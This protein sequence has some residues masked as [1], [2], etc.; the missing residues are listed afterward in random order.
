MAT[1]KGG[2][3]SKAEGKGGGLEIPNLPFQFSPPHTY[4]TSHQSNHVFKQSNWAAK[5]CRL[6]LNCR[7]CVHNRQRL[8]SSF[9][10]CQRSH[11]QMYPNVV[12]TIPAPFPLPSPTTN[13]HSTNSTYFAMYL[14]HCGSQVLR[15]FILKTEP[16]RKGNVSLTKNEGTLVVHSIELMFNAWKILNDGNG[17]DNH[18]HGHAFTWV[19]V[20]SVP[21]RVGA[22]RLMTP[23]FYILNDTL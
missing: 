23:Y 18:P 3:G 21:S 12:Y 17:I 19:S 15:S 14:F 5:I 1:V 10:L 13:S 4:I 2:E 7:V 9:T 16:L 6:V 11:S 20:S 22:N 8:V